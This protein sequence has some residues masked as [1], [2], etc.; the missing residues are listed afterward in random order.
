[1]IQPVNTLPPFQSDFQ[2]SLLQVHAALLYVANLIAN[3]FRK[4]IDYP[5]TRHFQEKP[6]V[7]LTVIR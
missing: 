4:V 1:M 3:P 7:K 5:N 6:R 2:K